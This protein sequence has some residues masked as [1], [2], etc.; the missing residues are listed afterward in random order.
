MAWVIRTGMARDILGG[1]RRM[2]RCLVRT[3]TALALTLM[4]LP[5][6]AQGGTAMS[7]VEHVWQWQE[8]LLQDGTVVAV[9]D[10]SRYRVEFMADGTLSIR[11]DCNIVLGTYKTTDDQV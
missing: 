2:I 11:A 4:V 10:S 3:L 9:N 6:I 8:T 7:L 1:R 5:Q